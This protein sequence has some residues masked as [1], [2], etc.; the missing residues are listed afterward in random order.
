MICL[1]VTNNRGMQ[2]PQLRLLHVVNRDHRIY[3]FPLVLPPLRKRR[4]DIPVLIE[5][6]AAQVSKRERMEADDVYC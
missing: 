4:E 2:S 5:H 1:L 3:V 6:F